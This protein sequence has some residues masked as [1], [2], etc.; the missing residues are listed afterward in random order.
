MK[1]SILDTFRVGIHGLKHRILPFE[2][3]PGDISDLLGVDWE[4]VTPTLYS[5]GG[6]AKVESKRGKLFRDV[7][8]PE[9]V[10]LTGDEDTPMPPL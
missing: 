4:E 10:D 8:L 7:T 5:L 2:D 6:N 3:H 9:T 1:D